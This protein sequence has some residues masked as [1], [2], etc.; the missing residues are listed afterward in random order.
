[1]DEASFEELIMLDVQ[2][3]STGPVATAAAS[4]AASTTSG[5]VV[6]PVYA[7]AFVFCGAAAWHVPCFVWKLD[8]I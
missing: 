3:T 2:A 6:D 7:I 4:D 8:A 5:A 1:M